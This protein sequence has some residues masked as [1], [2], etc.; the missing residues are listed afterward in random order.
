[1]IRIGKI[2]ATHG[3]QGD[4]VMTHITGKQGWL[5]TGDVLFL[6][7]RKDSYIPFFISQV[8]TAGVEEFV[9]HLEETDSVEAARKLVGKEAYVQEE[10]LA[11]SGVA[12]TP[13]LWIGFELVDTEK[14]SLGKIEDIFQTSAQWQIGRA[15]C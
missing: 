9:L 3:L 13:L 8:K 11:K 12:E 1:M 2:V 5:K 7:L 14:G 10:V 15:S 4:V 6:A